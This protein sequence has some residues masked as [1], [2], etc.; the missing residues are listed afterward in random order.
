MQMSAGGL[1][2]TQYQYVG[3]QGPGSFA[4]SGGTNSAAEID[5][6]EYPGSSGSYSL[7]GNGL[8]SAATLYLGLYGPGN[9]T[10]TGGTNNVSYR[11]RP[12]AT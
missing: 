12:A 1:S 8:L 11:W 9:F 5:L 10:Q 2:T 4:Q 7:T 3:Y 6:A